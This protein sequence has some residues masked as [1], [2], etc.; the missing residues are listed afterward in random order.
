MNSIIDKF[1]SLFASVQNIFE[2][3]DYLKLWFRLWVAQVF[4]LSGRSKAGDGYLEIN[5]FQGILFKEEYGISF[6]DPEILAQLA[7]YAETF[8]PLMVI[9]GLG[10]RIGAAGLLAM[11]LFI[12]IFVY[13]GH[14]IEHATWM[15]VLIPLML[16]GAGKIS[17][18][19]LVVRTQK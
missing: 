5:D 12:Q 10:T 16:F 9:A 3:V 18:D 11:T 14:F 8:F 17:L 19:Q 4:F 2:P 13:P 7:L 6:M 15:A 1:K